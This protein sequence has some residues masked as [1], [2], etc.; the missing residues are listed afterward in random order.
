MEVLPPSVAEIVKSVKHALRNQEAEVTDGQPLYNQK[1]SSLQL[2]IVFFTP[3]WN[4]ALIYNLLDS[5]VM[6]KYEMT[7]QN[8]SINLIIYTNSIREV[9]PAKEQHS[10]GGGLCGCTRSLFW[11]PCKLCKWVIIII[12]L[13]VVISAV[14]N[15]IITVIGEERVH[16]SFPVFF[17]FA[18]APMFVFRTLSTVTGAFFINL[19]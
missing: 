12:L 10:G 5:A 13:S 17:W 15:V 2:K 11:L 9:E 6:H 19:I 7:C 8:Q 16:T 3:E 1:G 4:V 18:M 14:M